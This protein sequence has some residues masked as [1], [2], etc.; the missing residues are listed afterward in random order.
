MHKGNELIW[1]KGE[2]LTSEDL[3]GI[4]FKALPSGCNQV[5]FDFVYFHVNYTN[6]YGL[7]AYHRFKVNDEKEE[8]GYER[9]YRFISTGFISQ[10]H[11]QLHEQKDFLK[12]CSMHLN[13]H[14]NDFSILEKK[15]EKFTINHTN[16][17]TSLTMDNKFNNHLV[18]G[19]MYC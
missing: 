19:K 14:P 6:Y 5:E 8:E 2:G 11:T 13:S 15:L 3:V 1:L 4:E 12:R 9:G 16:T 17:S 18:D 10:S 7:G